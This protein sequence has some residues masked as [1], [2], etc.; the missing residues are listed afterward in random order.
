MNTIKHSQITDYKSIISNQNYILKTK[1]KL[2]YI[3]N[4]IIHMLGIRISQYNQLIIKFL[5]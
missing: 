1:V 4:N 2:K 3:H 5:Y